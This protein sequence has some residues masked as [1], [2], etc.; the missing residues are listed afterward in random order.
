[1]MTKKLIEGIQ[2]QKTPTLS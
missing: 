2:I 1:M